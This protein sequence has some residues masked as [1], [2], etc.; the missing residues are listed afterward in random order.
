MFCLLKYLAKNLIDEQYFLSSLNLDNK[1]FECQYTLLPSESMVQFNFLQLQDFI[2]KKLM[3]LA[4]RIGI[5]TFFFQLK[6]LDN[7]ETKTR[8]KKKQKRNF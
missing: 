7:N 8:I 2:L 5:F 1:N 6:N 3:W 4:S